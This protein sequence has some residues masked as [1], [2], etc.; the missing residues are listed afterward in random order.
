MLKVLF[1]CVHN[2][3]RSQM[4]EAFLNKL[5]KG[6]FIAESAG[7][8]KGELNPYVVE[9]M[10]EVGYDIS[11]KQTNKV[12]D[13]FKEG[14]SYTYVIKVCDEINGQKCPIFRGALN[15]I[16]WNIK[17]PSDF[18]GTREEI[19]NKTREVRDQIKEKVEKFIEEY[20]DYAKLKS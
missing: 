5:G 6:Y 15:D 2:S 19:L 7:I 8:E 9:V 16:Y 18:K 4:G 17:D 1:V 10:N 11:H 12:F 3:A 13:F 20:I 14:R